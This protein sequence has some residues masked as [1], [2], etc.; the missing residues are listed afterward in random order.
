[1]DYDKAQ[2][3][4][5]VRNALTELAD[6]R[7]RDARHIER[8]R[9]EIRNTGRSSW[10]DSDYGSGDNR[11]LRHRQEVYAGVASELRRQ[12]EDE[13]HVNRTAIRAWE[14]AWEEIGDSLKERA[15]H[16]YY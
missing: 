6:E 12:A 10:S 4:A 1:A 2:V 14:A 7:E 15:T 3:R 11:T 8:M 13:D 5:M 16:P 9:T